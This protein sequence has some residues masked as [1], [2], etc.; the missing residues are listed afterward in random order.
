MGLQ[1]QRL[2]DGGC[3]PAD[4]GDRGQAAVAWT[5]HDEC[6]G[7]RDRLSGVSGLDRARRGYGVT[8]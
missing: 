2:L 5:E 1:A 8:L 7:P 4:P 6:C 3:R